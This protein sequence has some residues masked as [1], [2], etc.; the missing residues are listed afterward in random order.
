MKPEIRSTKSETNSNDQKAE[1]SKRARFGPRGFFRYSDFGFLLGFTWYV[2]G[3]NFLKHALFNNSLVSIQFHCVR[4]ATLVEP[5]VT[6]P[7]SLKRTKIRFVAGL[8]GTLPVF[9]TKIPNVG[10]APAVIVVVAKLAAGAKQ[11]PAVGLV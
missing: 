9:C 6:L 10:V 7:E 1:N 11:A 8:N 3:I 5:R 2:D 4:T